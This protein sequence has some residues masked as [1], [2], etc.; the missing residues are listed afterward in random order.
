MIRIRLAGKSVMDV[1]DGYENPLVNNVVYGSSTRAYEI[2]DWIDLAMA[3]LDQAGV[4]RAKYEQIRKL[5]PTAEA[6]EDPGPE[7]EQDP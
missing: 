2:Q 5:L 1:S 3:S 6:P 4:P 7:S